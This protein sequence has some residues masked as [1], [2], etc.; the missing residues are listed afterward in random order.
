MSSRRF[1]DLAVAALRGSVYGQRKQVMSTNN[2]S[3]PIG[4]ALA[5][6]DVL[7]TPGAAAVQDRAMVV[8]AEPPPVVDPDRCARCSGPMIQLEVDPREPARCLICG[9][10]ALPARSPTLEELG[11]LR[12]EG[13]PGGRQHEWAPG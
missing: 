1:Y 11:S 8:R 12:R 10:P 6:I 9:R 7:L 3:D 4:Q 13:Q 5:S 2:G